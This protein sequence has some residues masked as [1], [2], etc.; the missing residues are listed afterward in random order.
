MTY[1]R[2]AIFLTLALL[3]FTACETAT[4]NVGQ[5]AVNVGQDAVDNKQPDLE[6]LE[7]WGWERDEFGISYIVGRV[8]NNSD[9]EYSYAEI[10]FVL[11]DADGAQVGSTFDNVTDL[12]PGVTWKFRAMVFEDDAATAKVTELSGSDW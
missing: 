9:K 10:N 11:L 5:D 12:Q 6:L 7:G 3:V 8:R 1:K 2:I 4:S